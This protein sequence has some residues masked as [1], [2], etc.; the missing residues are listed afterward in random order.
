VADSQ[1]PTVL[2][3][4]YKAFRQVCLCVVTVVALGCAWGGAW[5]W[6]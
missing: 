2:E 3:H 4:E 5:S 1:F 6:M